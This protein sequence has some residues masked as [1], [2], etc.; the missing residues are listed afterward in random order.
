MTPEEIE[1][2]LNKL[3]GVTDKV[4]FAAALKK[5]ASA[6]YQQIFNEGHASASGTLK[7]AKEAAEARA[8]KAEED[9]EALQGEHE[10]LKNSKP[11]IAAVEQR[12]KDKY[13][14][15]EKKF[16][17]YKEGQKQEAISSRVSG[18]AKRVKEILKETIDDDKADSLVDRQSVMRRIQSEDGK[19]LKVLQPDQDIPYAGDDEAQLKALAEEL[20]KGVEAKFLKSEVER[21]TGDRRTIPGDSKPSAGKARFQNIRESVQKKKPNAEQGPNPDQQLDKAFGRA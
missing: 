4:A 11:D 16:T 9:L 14:K 17:D 10:T 2:L 6:I 5:K 19:N 13:E 18:G 15:L 8:T 1:E 12:W 7:G 21:G 20:S 3:A